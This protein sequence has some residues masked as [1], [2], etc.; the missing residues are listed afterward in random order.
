MKNVSQAIIYKYDDHGNALVLVIQRSSKD[1]YPNI[2]ELP[3]GNCNKREHPRDCLVR[4]I[5]EETGLDVEIVRFIDTYIYLSEKT[6]EKKKCF[7]YLCTPK[8]DNQKIVFKPNPKTKI[9]EHQ[10]Y[11]WVPLNGVTQLILQPDQLKVVSLVFPLMS[12]IPKWRHKQNDVVREY[13]G[14]IQ[15]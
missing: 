12:P 2:W 15:K 10:D 6:G 11:K 7:T 13:L 14:R 8:G 9:A 3:R 4:E 5:K 1:H